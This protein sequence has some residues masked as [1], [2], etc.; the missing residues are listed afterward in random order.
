MICNFEGSWRNSQMAHPV[1]TPLQTDI[2]IQG[3]ASSYEKKVPPEE[4]KHVPV[5]YKR[6]TL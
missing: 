6:D 5:S 1:L 2:L 4:R 3:L